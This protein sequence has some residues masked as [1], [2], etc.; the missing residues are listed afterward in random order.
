MPSLCHSNAGRLFAALLAAM[1]VWALSTAIAL[2]HASLVRSEP[3][4]GAR[5]PQP[6]LRVVAWFDQELD[7]SAS[8][9]EILDAHGN[10]IEHDLDGVDLNDPDHASMI[11][12]LPRALGPG[13]YTV[14]WHAAGASGG[15]A[16]HPTNG[17]FAFDVGD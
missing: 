10:A 3:S 5:L 1:P 12:E 4:D 14:R 11:V 13:H 7:E 6:P 9:I 15:H 2:A 8:T 16:G 17:E